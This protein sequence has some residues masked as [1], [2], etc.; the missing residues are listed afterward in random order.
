M[1]ERLRYRTIQ[2]YEFV[3]I[4]YEKKRFVARRNFEQ[5]FES[6]VDIFDEGN[7]ISFNKIRL[8][9]LPKGSAHVSHAT[10]ESEWYTPSSYVEAIHRTMGGIYIDPASTEEAIK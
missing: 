6:I 4:E 2:L 8:K 10:G 1:K 5:M 7:N 3:K 9:Y